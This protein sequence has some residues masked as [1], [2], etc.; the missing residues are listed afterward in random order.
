M[1]KTKDLAERRILGKTWHFLKTD[2]KNNEHM[3]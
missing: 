1:E 2:M 3:F